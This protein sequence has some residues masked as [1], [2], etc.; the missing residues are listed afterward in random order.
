MDITL[1]TPLEAAFT[2]F[3]SAFLRSMPVQ[4]ALADHVVDRFERDVGID[5]AAA[6]ADEQR[7]M[8]H[9]ARL[10]GLEHQA[11]ARAQAFADQIVMQ[12]GDREQRGHRRVVARHAAIAEHDDVDLVLLDHAPRHHA[13]LFHRLGEALLAARDAEQDGQ[14]ADAQARK[15]RA[16]DLRELLVGEDRPLR[17][18]RGGRRWAAGRA[19]CL[20]SRAASRPR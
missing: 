17:A 7:E 8:V 2:K 6:V 3:R 14:H 12:P 19:D 5:G 15:I 1:I 20:R 16:A 13:E 9:L 4:Q 11:D 10:A 18:R